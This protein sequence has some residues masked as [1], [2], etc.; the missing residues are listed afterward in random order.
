ADEIAWRFVVDWSRAP[1]SN[2]A[3]PGITGGVRECTGPEGCHERSLSKSLRADGAIRG[4]RSAQQEI[5][6][7]RG[8][9]SQWTPERGGR[10]IRGI[11]ARLPG[12]RSDLVSLRKHGGETRRLRRCGQGVP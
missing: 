9:V 5:S 2:T 10:G 3:A 4:L 7:G 11:D 6:T 8:P 12:R 1:R